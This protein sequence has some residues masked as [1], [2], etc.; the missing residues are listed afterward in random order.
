MADVLRG[1]QAVT[2]R[3]LTRPYGVTMQGVPSTGFRFGVFE[4]DLQAGEVR[5]QGQKIKLQEKPFQTLVVLLEHAGEL[6]TREQLRERLWPA[7]TFV[8]FDDNLNTA[9]KRVREALGDSAESPRYV[10]T[11]PRRGYRF[12]PPVD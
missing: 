6:V 11:V 4:V 1:T 3:V 9:V 5:K 7:D 12:L 8:Q 10:E 2:F